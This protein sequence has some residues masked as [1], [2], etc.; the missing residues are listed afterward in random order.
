M[1]AAP[2]TSA[3]LLRGYTSSGNETITYT[4]TSNGKLHI[5]VHGYQAGQFSLRTADQ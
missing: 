3:Y 4:P 5:G 1:G 2:T